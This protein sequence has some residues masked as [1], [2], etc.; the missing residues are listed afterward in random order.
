[1]RRR[2]GGAGLNA[3]TIG[4]ALAI[5]SAC[6]AGRARFRG[7]SCVATNGGG[8]C[9]GRS[10][11]FGVLAA[12]AAMCFVRFWR[13]AVGKLDGVSDPFWD[14]VLC[15]PFRTSIDEKEEIW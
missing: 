3:A 15:L 11:G 5:G 7:T 2:D 6:L 9:W 12:I 10:A 14:D 4:V 8:V 1:V 13:G